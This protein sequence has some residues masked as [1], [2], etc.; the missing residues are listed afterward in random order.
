MGRRLKPIDRLSGSGQMISAGQP[1]RPVT[2]SLQVGRWIAILAGGSQ[3]GGGSVWAGRW[4]YR[5]AV[6]GLARLLHN[7][8]E[9]DGPRIG[10]C[11][12]ALP[13]E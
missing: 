13:R 11:L 1:S 10:L 7:R 2:Y 6:T 12:F 3:V 9:A 4:A 5:E 8:G